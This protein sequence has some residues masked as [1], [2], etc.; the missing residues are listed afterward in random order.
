ML[1][2]QL[3]LSVNKDGYLPLPPNFQKVLDDGAILTV[4]FDRN[5]LLIPTPVF[6]NI[7]GTM[8]SLNITNPLVRTFLRFMLG[9]AVE[10]NVHHSNQIQ[11]PRNLLEFAGIGTDI[12]I[13]GQGEYSEIWA[14]C[15]WDNQVQ[16]WQS[17]DENAGRFASLY[18]AIG[19]NK[20]PNHTQNE[21]YGDQI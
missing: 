14:P 6:Q 9:N 10:V 13:I 4:G 20:T 1:I 5:L 19:Q 15:S 8:G 16:T 2:G 17:P 7:L 11:I 21:K 18:L 3:V 12:I